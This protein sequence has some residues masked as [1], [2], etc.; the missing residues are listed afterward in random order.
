MAEAY[1]APE[2]SPM[3]MLQRAWDRALPHLLLLGG[4]TLAIFVVQFGIGLVFGILEG[5]V[6][7]VASAVAQDRGGDAAQVVAALVRLVMSLG[8]LCITLPITMI[9]TGALARLALTTA[10]GDTPDL[11]AFNLALSK[12]FRILLASFVVGFATMVGMCFCFIPGLIVALA[13]QFFIFALMDTEL[14]VIASVQYSWNLTRDH[15]LN[16]GVLA[17][18]MA[19]I[20]LVAVCGTCGLGLVAVQPIALVAQALVYVHLSGRTQDFLPDPE[21]V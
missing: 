19:G 4:I 21:V 20:A 8:R 15:L 9:T 6:A 2:W 14:G 16:L 11:G 7:G 12:F 18:I 5:V 3:D 1:V 10:R 13:L 17:L